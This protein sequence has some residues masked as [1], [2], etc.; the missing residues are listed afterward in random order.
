MK[1]LILHPQIDQGVFEKIFCLLRDYY[2]KQQNYYWYFL[3]EK[4]T[5]W[6]YLETSG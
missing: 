3:R 6:A 2:R 4:M 5:S 1:N